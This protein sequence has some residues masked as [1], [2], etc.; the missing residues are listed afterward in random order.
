MADP[1]VFKSEY[2]CE[3]CIFLD[4]EPVPSECRKGRG[5][6]AYFHKPRASFQLRIQSE[7]I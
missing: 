3:G 6:M 4:D 1:T 2:Y 5:Q 7:E